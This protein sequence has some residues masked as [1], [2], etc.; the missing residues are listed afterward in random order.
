MPAANPDLLLYSAKPRTPRGGWA[1]LGGILL[2]SG[3]FLSAC[4]YFPDLGDGLSEDEETA[5]FPKLVPVETLLA[6]TEAE[7]LQPDTRDTLENRVA[8]LNRRA[9]GL[10]AAGMD[11]AMR[12]RMQ[13]GV[14]LT[15]N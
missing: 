10:R 11:D 9:D 7:N 4:T 15:G 5:A 14:I 12:D 6:G 13:R 3:I 8:A 1:M 2:A